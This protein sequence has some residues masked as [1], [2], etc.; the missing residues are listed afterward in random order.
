MS[1]WKKKNS[2]S[3]F[4]GSPPGYIGYNEAGQLPE[5][6]PCRPHFLILFDEIEKSHRDVFNVLQILEDGRLTDGKGWTMDIKNT[7]IIFTSNI[8]NNV[9]ALRK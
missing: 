5:A 3:R 9:L 8:G 2:V 4:I 1:T 7:L 6:V